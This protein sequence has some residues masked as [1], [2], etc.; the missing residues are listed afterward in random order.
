MTETPCVIVNVQRGGPSTGLP[1]SGSQGDVMQARWGTHGEHAIIALTASNNQDVFEITVEAFNLSEAFRTPVILLLDEVVAHTRERLIMPKPGEI[2]VV[3]RLR[4][5]VPEGTDYHPYLPREDGRLPM[6]D[7]GGVHRYNVTGLAH[8]M[9]GFPSNNPKIVY[10]LMR[11]LVDKIQGHTKETTR[12]KEFFIDDAE[13]LL[14]SYGSPARTALHVVED[15]R[16][17]GEKVGLLELQTLWP[18]P[19]EVVKKRCASVNCVMIV[20]MNMG[21]ILHEVK[22]AVADP[23]KVFL[24]N[25]IDGSFI[26]P[27]DILNIL[28]IIQ[29]KGA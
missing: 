1:T 4:T 7:F 8:D 11:H 24:A 25:Q 12:I 5:S 6:S 9:W 16:E 2:N 15:R 10:G 3:K 19:A 27:T 28:R 18:F 17:R 21:Q 22:K 26:T 13:Y 20:E 29:G 14:I 23:D